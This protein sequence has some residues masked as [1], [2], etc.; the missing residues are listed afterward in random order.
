MDGS[1]KDGEGSERIHTDR[2]KDWQRDRWTVHVW[3][4]RVYTDRVK[5][6][7][8]DRWTVHVRMERA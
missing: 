1:R 4:E 5:Y 3:I 2:V 6:G 8:R 7:Q